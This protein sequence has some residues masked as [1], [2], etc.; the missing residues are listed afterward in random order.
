MQ[1][2]AIIGLGLIG[3]S[4][5]LGLRQWSAQ[6]A[7]SGSPA[8]EIVG[9]DS[10]LDQQGYAKKLGAVDKTEWELRKTVQNADLVVIATP[11]RTIRD[12]FVDIA[13]AL[14]PGA[15]VTDTGST[16]TNVLQWS[17]ELLPTT[18]SFIGGHPM[19]GKSMSIEGAEATL[20]EGATW[21]VA[22]SVRASEESIR[23]VLGMITALGAQPYFLDPEEHDAYV[24]GISHMPFVVSAS[25]MNA[26]ASDKSWRDMKTL[27][28]GGF[29]DMTRLS[30]GS[31]AMHRDIALT[32]R[33]AL[34]RWIDAVSAELAEFRDVLTDDSDES[35]Q[36]LLAYFDRARD[37]RAEWATQTTREGEL[38]Q[39][40]QSELSNEGFGD[41][42]SRMLFGSFIRKR[43]SRNGSERQEKQSGSKS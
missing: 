4:I 40:T 12:I 33:A 24:A 27:T 37:S 19:A 17:Q 5:G 18:V 13:E 36:K 10:D 15:V 30:A 16:K 28:A 25:I 23:T 3:G 6:N 31:A 22:P 41:Q 39:G 29:R 8:L 9:F 32:N 43:G 14:K 11:V 2:V 20:F 38:L 35:S 34:L 21:C 7:K 1:R 42:M 26:L